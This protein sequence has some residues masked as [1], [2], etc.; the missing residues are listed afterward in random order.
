[1]GFSVTTAKSGLE[2]LSQLLTRPPD[3]LVL[4]PELPLGGGYG[5]ITMMREDHDVLLVPALIHTL[6]YDQG[7]RRDNSFPVVGHERKPLSPDRLA[8]RI[9]RLVRD[10]RHQL[11]CT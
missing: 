4:D 3:L 11:P 10:F 5:V 6:D 1:M 2:C 9:R 7:I 8:D